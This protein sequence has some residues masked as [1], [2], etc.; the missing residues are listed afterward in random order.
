[1]VSCVRQRFLRTLKAQTITGKSDKLDFI[2]IK[3][4][5]AFTTVKRMKTSRRLQKKE[6]PLQI[7]YLIKD[8]YPGYRAQSS[9]IRKPNLKKWAKDLNR[10]FTELHTQVANEH[11]KTCSAPSVIRELAA[12]YNRTRYTT[13]LT[14]DFNSKQNPWQQ[15]VCCALRSTENRAARTLVHSRTGTQLCLDVCPS[16]M[17]THTQEN[18]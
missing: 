8:L 17:T 3:H 12:N 4:F 13:H 16:N 1:M 5:C 18:L 9:I 14:D 7:R 6:N 11:L 2:K 15:Q 10:Y